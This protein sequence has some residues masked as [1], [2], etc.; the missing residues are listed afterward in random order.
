MTEIQD[1]NDALALLGVKLSPMAKM[2]ASLHKAYMELA[3]QH[4]K[5]FE[6]GAALALA[7]DDVCRWDEVQDEEFWVVLERVENALTAY[8]AVL[9]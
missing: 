7:A 9:T 1:A 5:L 3:E 8:Q 6:A 4:G 2:Y